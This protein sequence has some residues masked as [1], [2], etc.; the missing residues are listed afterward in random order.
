MP[1]SQYAAGVD[2]SP[3]P[4][5]LPLGVVFDQA[6]KRFG[7][8]LALRRVSFEIAPGEFLLL[9]GHNGSG[10]TTLLRMA[11]M[12]SKPT[13]GR[14]RYSG[15][16]AN[17]SAEIRQ[18]IGVVGHHTLLY[19]ELTA[20]E[21]LR[22]FAKLYGLP[23]TS[24]AALA[25]LEPAGL[26][27]RARD[28]VRTFSRGMR[29]RL[30]IARALLASPSLLLLDEPASGLDRAGAAWLAQTLRER[31]KAG[32]TVVMSSHGQ[33]ETTAL[34]TRAIAMRGGSLIA[35]SGSGGDVRTVIE[36]HAGSGE[37]PLAVPQS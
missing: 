33:N 13:S 18:R 20:E 3:I 35:D 22:F 31:K 16:A 30:A 29:Q 34:A 21:N 14:V 19:D 4:D 6:E 37:E 12:L 2:A 23:N 28:L 8:L 9:L 36:E 26:R 27:D 5:S 15:A 10:K 7:S 1:R 32:C 24:Q 17:G 11:A 25:A